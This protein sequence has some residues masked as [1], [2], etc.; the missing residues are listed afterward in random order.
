MKKENAESRTPQQ[1]CFER[2]AA[3]VGMAN[4]DVSCITYTPT[5]A[6]E[7]QTDPACTFMLLSLQVYRFLACC[8]PLNACAS[9]V[10]SF[11]IDY[12]YILPLSATT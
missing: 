6:M 7:H 4:H 3:L 2:F 1:G 12:P 5:A 11:Y 9:A 10:S 8:A